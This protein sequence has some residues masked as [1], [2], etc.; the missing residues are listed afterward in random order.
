MRKTQRGNNSWPGRW[1]SVSG[2]GYRVRESERG[3]RIGGEIW[4]RGRERESKRG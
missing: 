2:K 3:E 1:A 4:G